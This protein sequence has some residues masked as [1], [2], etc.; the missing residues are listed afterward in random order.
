VGVEDKQA[1]SIS[2]RILRSTGTSPPVGAY[3]NRSVVRRG[4]SRTRPKLKITPSWLL[5]TRHPWSCSVIRG[6][7]PFVLPSSVVRLC[8]P[9][10][11]PSFRPSFRP[12]S[13]VLLCHPWDP[14]FP[15]FLPVFHPWSG[16]AIRGFSLPSVLHPWSC[17]VIRGIPPFVLLHPWS[18]FAIRGFSLPS[19]RPS[20]RHP[21]SCSVIRVGGVCDSSTVWSRTTSRPPAS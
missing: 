2:L 19:V 16:F 18:G 5:A 9:W 6:I 10:V 21:W 3:V 1:I 14:P 20:V 15:S 12:S 8:H 13:V 17:S 4:D 11:F 7:S